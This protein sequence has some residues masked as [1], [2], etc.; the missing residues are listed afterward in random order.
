MPL[1]IDVLAL[2]LTWAATTTAAVWLA[3][4]FVTPLAWRV[5]LLL[6]LL[7]LVFT[8]KAFLRGELYGPADLYYQHAPWKAVAAE[9]GIAAIRNPI[10]SDLAFANLPWRAAVREA[11]VNGRLPL[12]NRY[13]LAGNPLL[14][15]AQAGVFHPSTWLGVF[16]P[17]ALSWTFSCAFTIF[18]ALLSAYVFFR[19]FC[20][21]DLA[22]VVGAAAWGFSTYVLFFD[23]WAVGPS[24]A[25]L[26]LLLLGLRRLA[27]AEEHGLAITTV[28]LVL[29]VLGGHPETLLHS[30]AVAGVYFLWELFARD[31]RARARRAIG[32]ALAAGLLA[33]GLA[34]PVLLPLL[35]AV[36]HS[37]EYAARRAALEGG[38]GRQSVPALEA[39][40]RLRPAVLPFAH[41]IYGR[42]PVQEER[43]DGSGM[44]LAYAGAVLFPLAA[45]GVGGRSRRPAERGRWIFLGFFLAG[46]A[47]GASAPLL[48]DA[49]SM[50]PGFALALNYRLVF[51]APLGL[52][53][54]AALGVDRVADGESSR[55]L[56]T[57]AMITAVVLALLFVASTGVFRDRDLPGGFLRRS[58][59]TEVLPVTLLI[60][61]AL[62]P[63]RRAPALALGLLVAQRFLEMHGTYPT[64]PARSLGPSLSILASLPRTAAPFR[65]VAVADDLRPN[66][67][68][69]YGLE[70]VRGYESLVLN[71][72]AQTYPLWC[73]PQFASHNA[74]D[75][76]GRP[77]F[78]FLNVRYVM[79]EP[80]GSA[81]DGW[82]TV[83]RTREGAMFE[84]PRVLPRAF[85]PRNVRVEPDAGKRLQEMGEAKD[86][87]ETVWLNEGSGGVNGS[88]T[89]RVRE[90]GAD[91][92]IEADARER[93]LVATSIPDWPGWRAR[94]AGDGVALTTVNHA[95]VGIWVPPGRHVVRLHYLPES[96]RFGVAL[97]GTVLLAGALLL[98]L[99]PA[100]GIP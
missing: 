21:S 2:W 44:P 94:S 88:A 84:N 95:F 11:F 41:G 26:P 8:G 71:R 6:A 78:S 85:V 75:D 20:R 34:A 79:S 58:I 12:W 73:R 3:R 18:L 70:D 35:E 68:A 28:A 53:G 47:Y 87:S 100:R 89:L 13:V 81:P 9:K 4:R 15:T 64:L 96:F 72:F 56:T 62:V 83:T 59:A 45:I 80:G 14:G 38:R 10:L 39:A 76:L 37:A 36:P 22:A 24:I 29:A 48:L 17:L 32:G 65:V 31:A 66:G 77:F 16:L 82:T 54:L 69:L 33:A 92:V 23:G 5:G 7:P 55:P 25:G 74:V 19:E 40:R 86:F 52:A 1:R 93:T 30:I 42:S 61:A 67:A 46:L 50:L 49:T 57:A 99:R 91:L 27:R 90:I 60:G 97:A 43:H 51:L 98:L 63:R